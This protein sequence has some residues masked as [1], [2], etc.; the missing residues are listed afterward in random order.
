M[1]SKSNIHNQVKNTLTENN[2]LWLKSFEIDEAVH[3]VE[4]ILKS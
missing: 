2:I 4:K 1:K 3:N